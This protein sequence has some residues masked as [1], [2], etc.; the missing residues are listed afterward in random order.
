[1]KTSEIIVK[2]L[3]A[4]GF[5]D[6]FS[7]L[8]HHAGS[9][10]AVLVDPCGDIRVIEAAINAC[11]AVKPEYILLTHGHHDHTSAVSAVREFFNAPVLA[12][13]VC[14]FP[15]ERTLHDREKLPFGN[16]DIEVLFSPG[17]S[18][19]SVCYHLT[20][21]SAVFTGDTLFI[22]CCGY[23]KP[24]KMFKTMREVLY[25]LNDSNIVYSGHDYGHVPFATLGEEKQTN[26]YLYIKELN[27][28]IEAVK[29]L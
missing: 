13:P 20:D 3:K 25:P 8:L 18:A 5:D 16:L 6:N 4:G 29:R 10:D 26:P 27:E 19:D 1:M 24:E 11:G 17:H 2:Q 15:H 12:H 9:G 23:C 7:Y 21:D 14:T 28:F 22:D